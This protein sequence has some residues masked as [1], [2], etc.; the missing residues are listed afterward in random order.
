MGVFYQSAVLSSVLVL[1]TKAIYIHLAQLPACV[2][3]EAA[4]LK[5]VNL[6]S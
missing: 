3:V 2:H 5:L 4:I 6:P 1:R